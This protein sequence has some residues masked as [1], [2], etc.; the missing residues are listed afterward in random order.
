MNCVVTDHYVG[1]FVGLSSG[2]AIHWVSFMG[3]V[4]MDSAGFVL[5]ATLQVDNF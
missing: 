5:L 3:L 2:D 1:W 4:G